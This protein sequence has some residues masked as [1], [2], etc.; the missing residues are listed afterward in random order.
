MSS[1]GQKKAVRHFGAEPHADSLAEGDRAD[2]QNRT[3]KPPTTRFGGRTTS[4]S[5]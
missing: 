3:V 4:S 5:S 1:R 2:G